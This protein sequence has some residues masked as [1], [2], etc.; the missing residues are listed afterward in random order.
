MTYYQ[1]LKDPRWQKKRLE[2]M[3]RD[4]FKCVSCGSGDKELQCHHLVYAE[5]G[6]PWDVNNGNIITL[7]CGC[8]TKIEETIKAVRYSLWSSQKCDFTK[9]FLKVAF[10]CDDDVIEKC[11]DDALKMDYARDIYQ[12]KETP[13]P[14]VENQCD[15][16]PLWYKLVQ[17]VGCASPFTRS[18]LLEA[19][20]VSFSGNVFTIGFDPDSEHIGIMD[21]PRNH[22]LLQ[23]K[24]SQLGHDNCK[25]IFIK[26]KEQH[27]LACQ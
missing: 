8:H 1:K 10:V 16:E 12:E 27:A 15:L 24:L 21:N 26:H 4:K 13:A 19:H 22:A 20:P 11:L 9:K 25:A 23:S 7:C 3:Q 2:V 14:S 18:Y 6:N 17:S 5:S